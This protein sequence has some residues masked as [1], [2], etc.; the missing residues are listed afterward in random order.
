MQIKAQC[1]D[2]RL[3]PPWLVDTLPELLALLQPLLRFLLQPPGVLDQLVERTYK[4]VVRVVRLHLVRWSGRGWRVGASIDRLLVLVPGCVL[5]L[6]LLPLGVLMPVL[7]VLLVILSVVALLSLVRS[8][9]LVRWRGL[10]VTSY[11]LAGYML[12]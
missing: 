4:H 2:W 3:P 9:G 8:W 5:L 1:S 7:T 12:H 6:P 10:T 11:H